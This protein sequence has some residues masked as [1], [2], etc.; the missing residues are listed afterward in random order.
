MARIKRILVIQT[1]FIGD[2]ILTLPLIQVLKD[3]F[4]DAAIDMVV[5]PR[6][7]EVCRTHA[8]LN[9]VVPYDKRGRDRGFGG[10]IRMVANL[11]RQKYDLALVPHRSL[12]S[13][14]LA[15]FAGIPLRIGFAKGV[16]RIFFNK[17][18]LYDDSLH[19]IERNLSLLRGIGIDPPAKELP[20]VVPGNEAVA[21]VE[22]LMTARGWG[23]N[24]AMVAVAPG[25]VW[26]T[27]RWLKERFA[28]LAGMF[29]GEGFRV[30]LVGGP[31]D[32]DLCEE[33][34]RA[35]GSDSVVSAAGKLSVLGSAELIRRSDLVISN[36]S[37]PLHLSVGVGTPVVG[38]FGA[39][40]PE[41]GFAPYGPHDGVV[42]VRGLSC[43]PCSIHGGT[44]CP[45]GT[46]DC[47]KRISAERVYA[48]A[49]T[50]LEKAR[51]ARKSKIESVGKKP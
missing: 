18:I 15:L 31:E 42:E 16:G 49:V 29:A 36:D 4:A 39:T 32:Q 50:V 25:T 5:V 20:R 22:G 28:E 47:M 41:F 7:A 34:R 21:E 6:S 8:S 44:E 35:S 51:L 43:R 45:I 30:V 19:E 24:E 1:A 40:V 23:P 37:A 2:V 46:F 48:K 17:R 38:I 27:K 10:F 11:R 9:R 13:A 33:I 3:F 26:N 14:L 12:R